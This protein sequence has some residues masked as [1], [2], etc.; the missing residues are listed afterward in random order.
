MNVLCVS[1]A[2]TLAKTHH[3]AIRRGHSAIAE[4]D[5]LDR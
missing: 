2:D 3:D 5:S 1:I 4:G